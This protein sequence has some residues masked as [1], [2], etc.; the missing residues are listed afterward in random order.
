MA[1]MSLLSE[2]FTKIRDGY[3]TAYKEILCAVVITP[4]TIEQ[5]R[6]AHPARK[7]DEGRSR[8]PH[9]TSFSLI[10]R[11]GNFECLPLL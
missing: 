5:L 2:K 4:V 3:E 9:I 6:K 10:S 1:A 7:T 11:R 8:H